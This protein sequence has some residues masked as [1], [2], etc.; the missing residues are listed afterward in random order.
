M[1]PAATPRLLSAAVTRR[2]AA[3]ACCRADATDGALTCTP[4]PSVSWFGVPVTAPVPVTV[5]LADP[6]EAV[7]SAAPRPAGAAPA[8][9]VDGAAAAALPRPA[10]M[11]NAP[12]SRAAA[13][14][15]AMAER[16]TG[17]RALAMAETPDPAVTV[18]PLGRSAA[19][20]GSGAGPA[21]R[22][23]RRPG[24]PG[25]VTARRGLL[26]GGAA[27]A[28]G[29]R[30][31][32]AVPVAGRRRGMRGS[33]RRI[34]QRD[35]VRRYRQ[36]VGGPVLGRLPAD[37]AVDLIAVHCLLFQQQADQLPKLR[38][39]RADELDRGMLGLAQQA[40]DL[41]VDDGL[42]GLGERPAGQALPAAAAEEHR[43]ALRVTDRAEG[44]R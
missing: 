36:R 22:P 28:R 32:G 34:R 19:V 44:W 38:P 26:P 21:A 37:N 15:P 35:T 25:A 31:A 5:I 43:A 27:L 1:S 14:V 30:L 17:D 9:P 29:G 3:L 42:G 2:T 4:M 41:A 7:S 10:P 11:A 33:G 23:A 8:V 20:S 16:T 18:L 13:A 12:M 40:G 6:G 39:V 24:Q